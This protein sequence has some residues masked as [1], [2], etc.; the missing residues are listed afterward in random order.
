M[1][2][3]KFFSQILELMT[4]PGPYWLGLK[5]KDWKS[6]NIITDNTTLSQTMKSTCFLGVETIIV[7]QL[8]FYLLEGCH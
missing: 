3:N 1:C 4:H 5:G 8:L 7:Q 6:W 2:K